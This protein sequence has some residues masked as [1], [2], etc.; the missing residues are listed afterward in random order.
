[1]PRFVLFDNFL[2]GSGGHNFQ[3][4]C[5]VLEAAAAQGYEPV[6]VVHQQCPTT[7]NWPT[8]WK[9]L[10]E[11]RDAG[12][13]RLG[14]G[15]DG[16]A[17]LP[18]SVDGHVIEA[19][20]LEAKTPWWEPWLS[21][22]LALKRQ[23]AQRDRQRRIINFAQD[24]QRVWAALA[25]T[26]HDQ[27]FFSSLSDFDLL[28]VARFLRETSGTHRVP[29]HL[30]F[31]F[32]IF[33]GPDAEYDQQPDRQR[34]FRLQFAHALQQIPQHQIYLY[35]T[36]EAVA[37]QYNRLGVGEFHCLPYP[38]SEEFQPRE[39]TEGGPLRITCAGA[40]RR[41]KGKQALHP[42]FTALREELLETRTMQLVVQGDAR[43]IRRWLPAGACVA[44][45]ARSLVAP[46]EC[47][48][49]PLPPEAYVEFVC[50][51]DIGLFLYDARRYF[52]RCSGVLVEMMA[53]G[54]PVV[55][56]AGCWLGQQV[57]AAN[58]DYLDQILLGQESLSRERI[59][60]SRLQLA[61]ATPNSRQPGGSPRLIFDEVEVTAG[62]ADACI[63]LVSADRAARTAFLELTVYQFNAGGK[64]LSPPW[65]WILSPRR[66]SPDRNVLVQ[67]HPEA[68]LLQ[69]SVRDAYGMQPP[70][71]RHTEI[72]YLGAL[73]QGGHRPA[74]AV[75]LTAARLDQ[76]PF[77]LRELQQHYRHYR[78]NAADFS[79]LW[80]QQHAAV[81]VVEQLEQRASDDLLPPRFAV[82]SDGP[83]PRPR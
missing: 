18:V 35:S 65:T 23:N 83:Q 59:D 81:R 30:Q 76:V 70:A 58:W 39:P 71:I 72:S 66:S 64:A 32:D 73:P 62:A 49:H 78:Q 77:L 56:P 42:L 37:A 24:C 43:Q 54:I 4:A 31:H 20:F 36:T 40:L 45:A 55:A 82:A 74:G 47:M 22:W 51:A 10:A 63:R 12:N 34:R 57:D 14:L 6:A 38:V 29:W 44:D 27:F 80:R 60:P 7:A 79:L 25:P 41:E 17:R 46:V 3:Y 11:F 52:S 68:R 8:G 75:G 21:P 67:L 26:E 13:Y 33:E 2:T 61:T 48:N 1:M 19:A 28:G 53:A 9:I 69:L 50:Q 5:D 16:R 15:P